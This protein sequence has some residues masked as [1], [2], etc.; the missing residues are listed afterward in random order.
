VPIRWGSFALLWL[1]GSVLSALAQRADDFP[2]T[3]SQNTAYAVRGVTLGA[4]VQFDSSAYREYK[5]GPSDQFDGFTWCQKT[6]KEK[7]RR[8]TFTATYSILHSRDGA[9]VYVNR[10][11]EPAF[12]SPNEADNDV[13]QY[14][15]KIGDSPRITKMPQRAGFPAGIL[16]SWGKVELEPLDDDST[17]ALAEEMRPTTKGYFIDFIGDFARSAKNGLPI[18]RISGGAGFVWV[19]SFDHRGR[20]TLRLVAVDASALPPTTTE[21]PATSQAPAT[22]QAPTATPAPTTTPESPI[23]AVEN[24]EPQGAIIN[25]SQPSPEKAERALADKERVDAE[26]GREDAEKARDEALRAKADIEQ[27][28]AAERTR[29]NAV[30][31]HLEAEKR[32]AEA[33]A[34]AMEAVAYAAIIGLIV[35][36]AIVACALAVVQRKK[37]MAAE[38]ASI[39]TRELQHAEPPVVTKTPVT[40]DGSNATMMATERPS[41]TRGEFEATKL[42]AV[43]TTSSASADDAQR[44]GSGDQSSAASLLTQVAEVAAALRRPGPR[45]IVAII[46]S[47]GAIGAVLY[48]KT[49]TLVP[50]ENIS[51]LPEATTVPWELHIKKSGLGDTPEPFVISRQ[52]NGHGAAADILGECVNRSVIFKATVLGRDTES[53]V[54]LPWDNKLE[55]YRNEAGRS[56]QVIYLPITVK[57]NDDEPQTIKRLRGEPY[58]NV[59]RLVTLLTDQTFDQPQSA[60]KNSNVAAV[61][62]DDLLSTAGTAAL[63]SNYPDKNFRIS[64]ARRLLVQFDTSKGAMSIK[65]G[66]DDPAIQKLVSFCQNQ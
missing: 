38:R 4:T 31:A 65:I 35:L 36:L 32:A 61:Q 50:N 27:A 30:L 17:K 37:T 45:V 39:A 25:T 8:G 16:A 58:R 19:A 44:S 40:T 11:Q 42:A 46:V 34:R 6:R 51:D 15:H 47:V 7:E 52:Q 64:E 21:T 63:M 33:K 3:G 23:E 41:I 56:S 5:C 1:L 26:H 18:Y 28:M 62:L 48:W 20:G 57:I 43:T 24:P 49:L 22:T 54:E 14:S 66:M 29:A 9:V 59:I 55:D 60:M 53:T 2:R 10:Y 13:Q 12:F